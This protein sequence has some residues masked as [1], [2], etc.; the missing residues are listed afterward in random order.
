VA[1]ID[2]GF[3]GKWWL[4]DAPDN[5]RTGTLAIAQDGRCRVELDGGFPSHEAVAVPDDPA[6]SFIRA[7]PPWPILHGQCGL[8]QFTLI[9]TISTA[10][11]GGLFDGIES[12][13]LSPLRVVRGRHLV[14]RDQPFLTGAQLDFDYLLFW[15]GL[16]VLQSDMSRDADGISKAAS[17]PEVRLSVVWRQFEIVLNVYGS[18][19]YRETDSSNSRRLRANE[20]ATI[21]VTSTAAVSLRELDDLTKRLQDLLTIALNRPCGLRSRVYTGDDPRPEIATYDINIYSR[22]IYQLGSQPVLEP[23]GTYFF[24]LW[25]VPF[26]TVLPAW[27]DL[28]DTIDVAIHMLAG[29][30]YMDAGY[31]PTRLLTTCSALALPIRVDRGDDLCVVS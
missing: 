20:R 30:H 24:A 12:Q 13:T 17:L 2:D 23:A 7:L 10:S 28:Y 27:L 9:D 18:F 16:T 31:T 22:Q 1:K 26:E 15:S 21:A 4:P 19:F 5:Q 14:D 11:S 6:A 29:Q 8:E 25:D 3:R